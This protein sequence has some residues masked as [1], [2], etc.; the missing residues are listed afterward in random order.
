MHGADHFGGSAVQ[1]AA[2]D[3]SVVPS[4]G[5]TNGGFFFHGSVTHNTPHAMQGAS[6]H[7]SVAPPR[8]YTTGSLNFDGSTS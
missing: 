3:S 8:G 7:S 6:R 5:S 2:Q 4:W 1:G